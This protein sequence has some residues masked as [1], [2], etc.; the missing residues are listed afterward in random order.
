MEH[1]FFNWERKSCSSR[2]RC[3]A[4]QLSDLFC[5]LLWL[6][7]VNCSDTLSVQQQNAFIASKW[8]WKLPGCGPQCSKTKCKGFDLKNCTYDTNFHATHHWVSDKCC[9]TCSLTLVRWKRTVLPRQTRYLPKKPGPKGEKCTKVEELTRYKSTHRLITSL[10]T[11]ILRGRQLDHVLS[12][13]KSV[14]S[15]KDMSRGTPNPDTRTFLNCLFLSLFWGFFSPCFVQPTR[16]FRVCLKNSRCSSSSH[17]SHACAAG[18]SCT[19]LRWE[20]VV[21][22]LRK[23]RCMWLARSAVHRQMDGVVSTRSLRCKKSMAVCQ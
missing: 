6:R 9:I 8:S 18:L 10:T 7:K 20:T 23:L 15:L 2:A 12:L 22:M 14:W 17:R 19:A 4:A 3:W 11:G 1:G 16:G 13:F 5:L 21:R